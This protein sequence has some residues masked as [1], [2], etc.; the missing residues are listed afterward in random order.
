MFELA[1]SQ[2]KQESIVKSEKVI[3]VHVIWGFLQSQSH[4]APISTDFHL[5]VFT[6]DAESES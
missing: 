4:F 3:E 2:E 5:L 1:L 6:I